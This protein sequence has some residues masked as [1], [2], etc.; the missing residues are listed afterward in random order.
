[1]RQSKNEKEIN[2]YYKKYKV[3][4]FETMTDKLFQCYGED[5]FQEFQSAFKNNRA[6]IYILANSPAGSSEKKQIY[7]TLKNINLFLSLGISDK[8][9]INSHIK[10]FSE[11]KKIKNNPQLKPVHTVYDPEVSGLRSF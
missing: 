5:K 10:S 1:M 3:N 4:A 7:D 6:L 11:D 8:N 9:K 2:D